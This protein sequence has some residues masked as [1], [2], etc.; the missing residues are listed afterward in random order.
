MMRGG[1]EVSSGG[2]LAGDALPLIL[3]RNPMVDSVASS[4]LPLLFLNSLP[5]FTIVSLLSS[6]P[7]VHSSLSSRT[8]LCKEH[9]V[10]KNA[11]Q[12]EGNV[13]RYFL[14]V[15]RIKALL[16]SPIRARRNEVEGCESSSPKTVFINSC[17]CRK[18]AGSSVESY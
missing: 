2:E 1:G 7:S 18:K 4:P 14:C 6:G 13:A 11:E 9:G 8:E 16:L 5:I 12:A 3:P 15:Y 17:L 10:K